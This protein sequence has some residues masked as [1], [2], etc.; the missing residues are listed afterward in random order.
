MQYA[1]PG[2]RPMAIVCKHPD[3]PDAMVITLQRRQKKLFA[4]AAERF[5]TP[6]TTAR[7]G[8]FG[9]CHAPRWTSTLMLKSDESNA[10]RAGK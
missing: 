1:F 10:G 8:S 6:S 4:D 2:F 7:E 3:R 5:I 9:M